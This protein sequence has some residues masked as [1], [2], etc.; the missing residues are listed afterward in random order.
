MVNLQKGLLNIFKNLLKINLLEL[1][2]KLQNQYKYLI[3]EGL[4]TKN[5]A[6][7]VHLKYK[8]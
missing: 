3:Y 4:R 2:I 1:S 8:D 6:L 7:V 5:R